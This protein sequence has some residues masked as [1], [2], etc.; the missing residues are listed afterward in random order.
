MRLLV[1]GLGNI[2]R[3]LSTRLRDAGHYVVGTTTTEAK[4]EALSEIVDEVAVLYGHEADKLKAAA[5]G[6]DCIV[7]TVAPNAQ[8]SRTP[9]E[10]EAQYRQVLVD[11]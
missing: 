1:M 2:G 10:R 11:S 6:C 9:E 7:V 4:V 3:E 8:K 5:E